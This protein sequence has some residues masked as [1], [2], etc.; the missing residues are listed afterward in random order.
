MSCI[1]AIRN[2][3]GVIMGADSCVSSYYHRA[4]PQKEPK[5][6]MVGEYIFGT[7]G[8][9]RE[10]Q[11]IKNAIATKKYNE[12]DDFFYHC[13]NILIPEI[14]TALGQAGC[15]KKEREIE[16][17]NGE[18]LIGHGTRLMRVGGS[19]AVIEHIDDFLAIGC[20]EEWAIGAMYALKKN[21]KKMSDKEVLE[22]ALLAATQYS[23]FVKGPYHFLQNY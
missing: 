3:K 14:K 11:I 22:N 19:F 16:E 15:L 1:V 8:G 7:A 9:A 20:G 23:G 10:G 6:K 18:I 4:T 5:I 2:D 17:F 13:I 12:K 21:M